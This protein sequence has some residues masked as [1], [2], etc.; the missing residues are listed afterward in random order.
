MKGY[1]LEGYEPPAEARNIFFKCGFYLISFIFE[2][3]YMHNTHNA[4]NRHCIFIFSVRR[5]VASLEAIFSNSY[6]YIFIILTKLLFICFLNVFALPN[7][8]NSLILFSYYLS[9]F[10]THI[11]LFSLL[12]PL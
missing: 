2:A 12:L 4:F 7:S 8:L 10:F 6:C 1:I 5:C 3:K 11:S 9:L